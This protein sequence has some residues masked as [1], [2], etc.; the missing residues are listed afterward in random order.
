M[1]GAP[2]ATD[3]ATRKQ[4]SAVAAG[5]SVCATGDNRKERSDERNASD[6]DGVHVLHTPGLYSIDAACLTGGAASD[7]CVQNI[8]P[9]PAAGD[10]KRDKSIAVGEAKAL[11]LAASPTPAPTATFGSPNNTTTL[12]GNS[13]ER[14]SR[15]RSRARPA[16]ASGRAPRNSPNSRFC[17]SG[18]GRSVSSPGLLQGS[19]HPGQSLAD[20]VDIAEGWEY[21]GGRGSRVLAGDANVLAAAGDAVELADC[22]VAVPDGSAS[23]KTFRVAYGDGADDVVRTGEEKASGNGCKSVSEAW[24]GHHK[25]DGLGRDSLA[26]AALEDRG[27]TRRNRFPG[28]VSE[29]DAAAVAKK[30]GCVASTRTASVIVPAKVETPLE[31]RRATVKLKVSKVVLDAISNSYVA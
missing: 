3:L 9:S 2:G 23:K 16:S 18:I 30:A 15:R 1:V 31:F 25:G 13:I 28:G 5:T 29:L 4:Y 6:P 27:F 7:Q 17:L 14:K 19:H 10:L 8:N 12:D 11:D 22:G 26:D 20:I 24:D 21:P